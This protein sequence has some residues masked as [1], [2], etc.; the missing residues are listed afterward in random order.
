MPTKTP[1]ALAAVLAC[2]FAGANAAEPPRFPSGSVWHTDVRSAPLHAQSTSMITTLAGR[3]GWGNNNRMQIDFSIHVHPAAPDDAPMRTI[4]PH[5][6]SGE[7]WT[8]DCETLP[9]SMPV[10]TDTAF[11]GQSGL[12]CDNTSQ[13]CHLIVRKGNLLYELYSGNLNGN[14]LDARCLA[15]WNLSAH[16]PPEGRGEHCT[17]ADAAGFP[18]APLLVNADEIAARQGI[19]DADLGHAIR[20]ILPNDRMARDASLG[21]TGGRLYVRPASHAGSPSGPAGSVPYGARLRLK[22]GFDM[23]GYSAAARVILRTMQRYGIVLADGGNIALN[24]ETDRHTTA[25]WSSLG[26]GPQLFWNGASGSTPLL[27]THFEVLDTGPR[28]AETWN[29]VRSTPTIGDV[30]FASGFDG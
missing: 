1:M 24:F 25:K 7:Y 5:L 10:P 30:V 4:V 11:E 26:I 13:D 21:G 9:A 3:G 6:D 16:Y 14:V 22:A 23:T 12:S 8:P 15:V 18:I 19:A 29:C 28:I 17:S 2:A 20:F 27:V